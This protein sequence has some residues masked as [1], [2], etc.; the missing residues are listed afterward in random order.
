MLYCRKKQLQLGW[1]VLPHPRF[2]RNIASSNF[3]LFRT[4]QN[5]DTEETIERH[6][7]L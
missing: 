6:L 1:D 3:Y 4:L 7:E 2:S 5:N